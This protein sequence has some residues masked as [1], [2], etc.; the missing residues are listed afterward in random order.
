MT[1][2]NGGLHPTQ[3]GHGSATTD[4][5]FQNAFIAKYVDFE[6]DVNIES[7]R[8]S[9]NQG[10]G[11]ASHIYDTCTISGNL[12]GAGTFCVKGDGGT[13]KLAL[14][15]DNE[16][17]TGLVNAD[18]NIQFASESS[19]S[20]KARWYLNNSDVYFNIATG[21]LKLGY[22]DAR[23]NKKLFKMA[24]GVTPDG[25]VI[26]VGKGE[27]VGKKY[28]DNGE[29]LDV[30]LK[31]VAF[32]E[33]EP[34]T[35][36]YAGYGFPKIKVAAGEFVFRD[37]SSDSD[38]YVQTA[39]FAVAAT[40]T[41][42]DGAVVSGTNTVSISSLTLADGAYIAGPGTKLTNIGTATFQGSDGAK[43]L[44]DA[45]DLATGTKYTLIETTGGITG[46]PYWAAVDATGADVPASNGKAKEWWLVNVR[47]GKNLVLK[48]GNPN[49]G[50]AIVVR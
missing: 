29:G 20:S 4:Y 26:E 7:C 37:D 24:D 31:K 28:F 33:D 38:A 46:A 16:S 50:L 47:S 40:V 19:G 49:V 11:R 27:M 5:D 1:S 23:G 43:V 6:G 30:T 42:D 3:R 22:L 2:P 39:P 36:T 17:F 35:F 44:A 45:A 15:G 18:R 12:V 9:D 13:N 41:V 14:S 48:E 32:S 21:T 25:L 34:G 8:E 10:D